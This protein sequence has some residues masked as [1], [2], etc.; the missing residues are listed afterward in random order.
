MIYHPQTN[1]QT[2]RTNQIMEDM[3][4]MYVRTKPSKWKDYLQLV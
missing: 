2:E 3:L 4:Y 1:G